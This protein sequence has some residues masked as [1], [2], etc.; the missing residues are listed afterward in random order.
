[1]AGGNAVVMVILVAIMCA[2]FSAILPF[3]PVALVIVAVCGRS[4]SNRN[5]N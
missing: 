2:L 5:Q 1:M 4:V 3:I